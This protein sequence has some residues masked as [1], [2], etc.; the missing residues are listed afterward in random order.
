ME[1][2]DVVTL[3]LISLSVAIVLA[4]TAW[5]FLFEQHYDFVVEAACDPE[6]ETCFY[7]EC[8]DL[9]NTGDCPPNALENYKIFYLNAAD[10]ASCQDNSC[11]NE[12][13][14]GA[15]ECTELLCGESEEDECAVPEEEA[16]TDVPLLEEGEQIEVL[17]ADQSEE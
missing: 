12:C 14:T 7:R 1:R 6:T 8:S 17:E 11:K 9:S 5:L 16:E 15:I 3:S 4:G 13:E 10:F 2:S